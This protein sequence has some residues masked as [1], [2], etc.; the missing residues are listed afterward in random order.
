MTIAGVDIGYNATKVYCGDE[1]KFS[2][3]S[4]TGTADGSLMKIIGGS[5]FVIKVDGENTAYSIGADAINFSSFISRR[6][7]R[8]WIDSP[9]WYRFFLGSLSLIGDYKE[10]SIVTGLPIAFFSDAQ[11]LKDIIKREHT[12]FIGRDEKKATINVKDVRVVPQPFGTVFDIVFDESGEIKEPKLATSTIGVVDIGGKTT[13]I[14]TV[15]KLAD[16]IKQT[17]S[18]NAGGWDIAR[19]VKRFIDDKFPESDIKEHEIVDSINNRSIRMY[20]EDVD[21]S[22][23]VDI[24]ISKISEQIIATMT[25]VW[26]TGS[27][28]DKIIITGGGAKLI[29]DKIRSNFKHA[30][31]ANDPIFANSHG[32]YKFGKRIFK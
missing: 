23:F 16:K 14:L 6:E 26:G 27:G 18:V 32:Y 3:P 20:G 30:V 12:F 21:I 15:H 19:F 24:A 31:V 5:D 10:V 13:N 29:G 2:F 8:N 28:I 11:H 25:Q 17:T 9:E 22:N 4:I 7:D 1:N